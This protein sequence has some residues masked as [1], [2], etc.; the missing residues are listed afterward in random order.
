MKIQ[1]FYSEAQS[2]L[3]QLF[4]QMKE[5]QVFIESWWDIDHICFRVSTETE[6]Q[7]YRQHFA[8]W[9]EC[10]FESEVNGRLISTFKLYQH[11]L[12]ENRSIDLVEL[13]APKK[14]KIVPTGFEHIEVVCE[15]TFEELK[16][17]FAHCQIDDSGLK[18]EINQELE[19]NFD[20][21]ALKF[22]HLSLESLICIEKNSALSKAIANLGVLKHFK[23]FSPLIVGTF[24]LDLAMDSSDIDILMFATDLNFLKNEL[25]GAYASCDHFQSSLIEN[26]LWVKFSFQGYQFEIF[27]QPV[28]SSLQRAALHFQIEE[29]LLKYGGAEFRQKI[30]GLRQQGL[31]T[32]PAFA[33]LLNLSGD[34]YLALLDLQTKPESQ[35]RQMWLTDYRSHKK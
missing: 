5:N 20:R 15:E 23:S 35:I 24:P 29:R 21:V 3:N 12:F 31:K 8:C 10:L 18:K 2:F 6:Y 33:Q 25:A 26:E 11:I 32:E 4:F 30:R 27:A 7:Q 14:G 34:P 9:G 1:D 19:I 28:P 22:H 16:K 17:R 13:P